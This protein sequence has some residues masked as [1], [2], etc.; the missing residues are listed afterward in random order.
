M[1]VGFRQG[2]VRAPANF[3]S[4]NGSSVSLQVP[5]NDTI[6]ATIADGDADY[7]ISEKQSI[8]DAW[9]GPFV[10]NVNYWLYWDIHLTTG[11]RTFGHTTRNPAEGATPPA[12]PANTQHWFDTTTNEMK[13]FNTVANRWIRV[14]RVFAAG[15][16]GGAV[17]S[18]LGPVNNVFTGT[19]I[20]NNTSINAGALMFDNFNGC[21]KKKNGTYFTTEDYAVTG[22]ASSS[23]V[24]M[25]SIQIRAEA[26]A[27]IPPLSIVKF[28]DFN[29]V[30]PASNFVIDK[31]VYGLIEFEANMGD[32]VNVTLE[33]MISHGAWDWST[34]GI[35]TPLYV[36]GYGALTTI[37]SIPPVPVAAIVDKHS[38][39]LRPSSLF[40]GNDTNAF[41][42]QGTA[43]GDIIIPTGLS[44]SM[45]DAPTTPTMLAN[46]AYVDSKL[47]AAGGQSFTKLNASSYAL[48]KC[49]PVYV[50]ANENNVYPAY[51]DTADTSQV[52]GLVVDAV[53]NAGA[54]GLIQGGGMITATTAQWDMI[55]G[56]TGG[57][58]ASHDY[59]L[60]PGAQGGLTLTPVSTTGQF[61]CKV[62]RA[63]SSTM[64]E[65]NIEPSIEL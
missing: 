27:Y 33:G 58:I 1:L 53:I 13:V 25:G 2:L 28:V 48:P 31:V 30:T 56:T 40:L 59:F 54:A 16:N 50:G 46:K 20:G 36:D 63:A 22:V 9:A 44:I 52:A 62:G 4:R 10:A 17:F 61:L 21:L 47:V 5:P 12:N 51:A 55:T 19:Q 6:I 49:I 37:P 11:V 32:V 3:L 60:K 45:A 14:I 29:K 65:V 34:A 39:L 43:T 64:M 7:L 35:N 26:V 41:L 42:L 57:L 18:S 24:K 38:I 15:Y 8:T 23:Q